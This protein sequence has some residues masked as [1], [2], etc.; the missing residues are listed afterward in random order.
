M[1]SGV[2]V[3]YVPRREFMRQILNAP[4]VVRIVGDEADEVRRR[5][6]SFG[7]AK[8]ESNEQP[9]RNRAHAIVYTPSLHA[10]RSNA[11]HNSL[12]KGLG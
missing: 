7:T 1:A 5:A 4:E 3:R 11:K 2:R 6:E 8:Y 12:L 9:G 10:I